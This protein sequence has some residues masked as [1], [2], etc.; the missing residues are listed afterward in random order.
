MGRIAMDLA[1]ALIILYTTFWLGRSQDFELVMFL[2]LGA[3]VLALPFWLRFSRGR[4]KARVFILGA[5][6][7]MVASLGLAFVQ[8]DWPRWLIFVYVPLVGLGYAVVDLM[9][10]SMVGEVI[11]E[12]DLAH[13]ERREGI[14][15]GVF[16]FVRKL[17]GALGVFVVLVALDL[18]GFE[19]G[20]QQSETARQ[21]IR[22]MTAAGPAFF[23]A[24]AVWVARGYPLTR[25]RHRQILT[26]LAQCQP[27]GPRAS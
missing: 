9:P 17:G 7:W 25:E 23:L 22:W 12:D 10:W 8:P 4:D 15:N 13:G 26:E 18:L 21:A 27:A 20:E 19:K 11:D 16:T 24:F 6:W 14:Y 1:G 3:V 2:F 5:I